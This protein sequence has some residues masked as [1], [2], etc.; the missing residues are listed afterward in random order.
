M[1]GK[2]AEVEGLERCCCVQYTALLN[3]CEEK[4]NIRKSLNVKHT[5]SMKLKI[6]LSVI[7][8]RI[9]QFKV[10]SKHFEV[11]SDKTEN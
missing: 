7:F 8:P 9:F 5:I 1:R 6:V 4:F 10:L 11:Y 3:T 2:K